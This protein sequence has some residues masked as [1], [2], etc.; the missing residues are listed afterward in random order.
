MV[1]MLFDKRHKK[2]IN[3]IWVVICVLIIISMVILYMP[4]F[5]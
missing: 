3:A 4:N 2:K 1:H 5:Q